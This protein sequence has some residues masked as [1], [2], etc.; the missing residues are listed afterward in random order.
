MAQRAGVGTA[1]A[2]IEKDGFVLI[3]VRRRKCDAR[4]RCELA[5]I[6]W[7]NWAIGETGVLTGMDRRG[8]VAVGLC[9]MCAGAAG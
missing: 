8:R 1:V 9:V 2:G 5:R 6:Q 4:A 3:P 7:P